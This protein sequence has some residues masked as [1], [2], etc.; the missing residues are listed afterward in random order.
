MERVAAV[1]LD[2]EDVAY[3]FT[4]LATQRVVADTLGGRPVVVFF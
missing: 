1:E 4:V 2:G 3:P